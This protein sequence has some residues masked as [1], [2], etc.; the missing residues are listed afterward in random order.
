MDNDIK[1]RATAGE[2]VGKG[3]FGRNCYKV[4]S[5]V[6]GTSYRTELWM[7]GELAGTSYHSSRD[8]AEAAGLIALEKATISGIGELS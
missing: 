1:P 7:S 4:Y 8:D 6:E 5:E 2:L 3:A